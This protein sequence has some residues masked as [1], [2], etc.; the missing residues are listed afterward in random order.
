MSV[1]TR[2]SRANCYRSSACL[3]MSSGAETPP[4]LSISEGYSSFSEGSQSSIDLSH[5]NYMLS[6][7]TH[8][9]S[10]AT[11]DH[12]QPRARD[13]G[14]RRRI[15][16]ARASRAS[17]YDTIP[18]IRPLGHFQVLRPRPSNFL[19]RLPRLLTML[20]VCYHPETCG[21]C[22]MLRCVLWRCA[23]TMR[24]ATKLTMR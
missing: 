6:N 15:Y 21:D 4:P 3:F 13:H 9:L 5:V 14:H 19:I 7:I 2:P 22:R 18:P 17:V 11:L 1:F 24:F 20:L 23:S 12:V 16:Q 10:N 8:P